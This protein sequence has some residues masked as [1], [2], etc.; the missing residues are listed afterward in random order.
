M[1]STSTAQIK[2]RLEYL[3]MDPVIQKVI[4]Y[5]ALERELHRRRDQQSR[6]DAWE[7]VQQTEMEDRWG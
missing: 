7:A 6:D 1:A 2:T 5:L 4:D 3:R